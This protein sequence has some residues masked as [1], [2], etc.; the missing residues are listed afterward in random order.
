[1]GWQVNLTH[2]SI[3]IS[4]ECARELTEQVKRAAWDEY[5][6]GEEAWAACEDPWS[7]VP[8]GQP[9][10]LRFDGEAMEH[11]DY[12]SNRPI[13]PFFEIMKKYKVNGEVHFADAEHNSY[14]GHRFV[15]GEYTALTG[16]IKFVPDS[17]VEDD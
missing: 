5:E 1:M 7:P 11:I 17:E 3:Q 14:W 4:A 2:N 10:L 8:V 9:G 13:G 6:Y 15:D 16:V 12:I